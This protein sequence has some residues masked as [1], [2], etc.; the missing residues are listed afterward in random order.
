MDLS[1]SLPTLLGLA[2]L[3]PLA[4]FIAI[5]FFGPRMGHHGKHAAS[6]ATAAIVTSLALSLVAASQWLAAHPVVAVDHGG[7]DDHGG[8]GHVSDGSHGVDPGHAIHGSV[9][10]LTGDWY[11]LYQGGD[12]R[13][14]IGWYIDALTILMFVVVT[15]I[16]TCIH[17]YASGYMH[18]ELHDVTD[19]EVHLSAGG[20]LHRPGRFPRFFQALSLFCFSMLGIVIAGNLAMVFIFWELV[21]ICSWFLIGFYYERKSASTAANKAF[22][23]NRVGDFGMLIGLMALWGALGTLHFGDV[24]AHGADGRSVDRPGLFS[25]V[26][27]AAEGHSQR[28][29]DGMVKFAAADRVAQIAVDHASRPAD[30][31]SEIASQLADW[32]TMGLGR[33]LLF[34][35]GVGIFCGCVGK[36]A[37]VPLFV[38][39]PDAM[40]GP[41]P[42]S[43]LVHSATMVAAGVYLVGRFYPVLTP[44]VLLVIAYVG[45]ITLFIAA[46]IALVANDIK[47]VLAYSTVSQL[48]YM[49]LALGVG[50]WVAGLFHLVTHAFFK[51]LLFLCSGSVIHACHTNDMRKMGGLAKVMPW[52]AGTMLVGCLAIIGAGVPF[53]IGLSGYYSKDAILAQALSF[54]RA[55]PAHSILFL[56]VAGG[57]FLTA[58]YMFRLWFMT[59]AGT[60]RDHHVAEHAH[61]SPRVMVWPLVALAVLAAVAGWTMPGGFGLANLLEQARP[62]GTEA[63]LTGGFVFGSLTYPAEHESHAP[64]IHAAATMTAFCTA[65]A[66]VALAAV[67]YLWRILSPALVAG[68]FKPVYSFLTNRWYVDELYHAVFVLP[69]L[70]IAKFAAGFDRNVIDRLIDGIAWS[71]R[72]LAGIDA[73]IDRTLVDGLVNATASATWTAGMELKRLQTGRLRQYVMFIVVGTV[74]LFVLASILFRSSL[75]G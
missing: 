43:A 73:W 57:A 21:G 17:F 13:L 14:T 50:G 23:V 64:A 46:T 40:E 27:P 45:A 60:P 34:V 20:H 35:A 33:W 55:N 11:T 66:G 39:L 2:W 8:G 72:Q 26:R 16:A 42:V 28:V 37:Q 24:S 59:F 75:A 5:L 25:L 61:E 47:R 70:G 12:L 65:L 68:V 1:T 51:S 32:R 7:H 6:V 4:S 29:P 69:V 71:A 36:S 41:T 58:F 18:D 67:M 19:H 63:T 44:D 54:A 15:F 3:A 49:M 48:G 52:T 53:V 9:A 22:I 62:A 74:A 56:A 38:W 10:A 30:G 31:A